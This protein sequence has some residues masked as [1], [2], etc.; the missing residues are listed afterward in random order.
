MDDLHQL[1]V[2]AKRLQRYSERVKAGIWTGTKDDLITAL[3]DCA[4]AG[5]IA[6]RLYLL[7]QKH[8]APQPLQDETK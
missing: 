1:R 6:R 2:Q 5:E 3:A 4:E 8:T 7:L